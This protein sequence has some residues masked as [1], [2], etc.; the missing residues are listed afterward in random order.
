MQYAIAIIAKSQSLFWDFFLVGFSAMEKQEMREGWHSAHP[1]F[2]FCLTA[3]T[4]Y[5]INLQISRL[6]CPEFE[7]SR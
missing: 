1:S 6:F 7:D 3:S 2:C 4:F 5:H